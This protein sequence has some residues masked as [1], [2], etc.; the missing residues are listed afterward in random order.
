MSSKRDYYEVLGVP[1][2][3]SGDD[4]KR[5]FRRMARQYHPDVNKDPGAEEQFK[6]LNEAYEVRAMRTSARAMTVLVTRACR[7]PAREE[8][9]SRASASA[10]TTSLRVFLVACAP[11]PP[12]RGRS[13]ARTCVTT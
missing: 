1:R 3:A 2:N 8:P 5:A 6:E 12:Q 11:A 10:L 13:A 9:G 7:V 4:L